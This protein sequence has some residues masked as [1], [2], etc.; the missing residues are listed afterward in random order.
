MSHLFP[1]ID[2]PL[3]FW[4]PQVSNLYDTATLSARRYRIY[5]T[6]LKQSLQSITRIK[7]D[8]SN[9]LYVFIWSN[10]DYVAYNNVTDKWILRKR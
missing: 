8:A 9:N 1:L 10:G 2:L 7:H 5:F 6:N 3:N 4:T